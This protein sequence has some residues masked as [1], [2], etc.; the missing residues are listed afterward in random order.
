VEVRGHVVV[1]R[2]EVR[3]GVVISGTDS[4]ITLIRCR[5]QV[6]LQ[7]A[8]QIFKCLVLQCIPSKEKKR[9]REREREEKM[10]Y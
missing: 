9:E 10:Y 1:E 5:I 3:G 7:L 8:S 2:C 4:K 6:Y